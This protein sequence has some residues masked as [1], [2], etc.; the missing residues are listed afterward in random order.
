[1]RYIITV[2]LRDF[3]KKIIDKVEGRKQII[4]LNDNLQIAV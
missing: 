3:T 2:H 1:M 4:H